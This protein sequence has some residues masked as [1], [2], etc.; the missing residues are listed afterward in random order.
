MVATS[1]HFLRAAVCVNPPNG[2]RIHVAGVDLL[3][4]EQG[5]F[6]VLE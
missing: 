2:V 3:C 4:D 1:Q 5:T 6:R